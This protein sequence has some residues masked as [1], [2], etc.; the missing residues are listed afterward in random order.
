MNP[1]SVYI[2]LKKTI[3][4][5]LFCIEICC[6]L[7]S[8]KKEDAPEIL[9]KPDLRFCEEAFPG[10]QGEFQNILYG[11]YSIPCELINEEYIFQGDVVVKPEQKKSLKGLGIDLIGTKWPSFLIPYEI[12]YDLKERTEI[13]DAINHFNEQ[14]N[15][16][17]IEHTNE[18][19]YIEFV[20][21]KEGCSSYCGMIGGKQEIRIADWA[22]F[23]NIVHEIGH[24]VGLLHEHSKEKR[25]DYLNINWGNIPSSKK[26]NFRRSGYC[27]NSSG[28]DFN[29]VMLFS[30]KAFSKQDGLKTITKLD[31]TDI[32][33]Q[34]NKLSSSDIHLINTMY[35][36]E[37]IVLFTDTVTNIHQN[38]AVC[39]GKIIDCNGLKIIEKGVCWSSITSSPSITSPHTNNGS[40]LE[41]YSSLLIGLIP[42]KVHYV[43]SYAYA[44]DG[45][46]YY[47]QIRSFTTISW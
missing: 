9:Y 8:C 21:D 16:Q 22:V 6:I 39:G 24:A 28:F 18:E 46:Y 40:G 15:I 41:N 37:S 7:L 17:F 25:D 26:H 27:L 32:V 23:G 12:N 47:G 35:P 10:I 44:N 2:P 36:R 19:N 29:S 34:R 45:Q 43:C 1:G 31:G 33:P 20:W 38:T 5:T 11:A 13:S 42:G 14:T 30:S 3:S 4:I